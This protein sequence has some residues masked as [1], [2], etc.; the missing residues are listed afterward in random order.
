MFINLS[1]EQVEKETI[2]TVENLLGKKLYPA[3]AERLF[4]ES[5]VVELL[6]II[7]LFNYYAKQ[8][9]LRYA[10]GEY[11]DAIAELYGVQRLPAKPA[12]TTLRFYIEEPLP[13]DV[14]I[15]A[16]TRA[17]SDG[18]LMFKTTEEGKIPAGST[19]VDI[20]AECETPGEVGNGYLPG[21]INQLVDPVPYVVKVENITTS[22]G[23]SDVESDDRFRERIRLSLERFST[24]GPRLA[25]EYWVKTAHQDI[26]DV[27]VYSPSEG[28]VKVH[29]LVKNGE[30]PSEDM[31]QLVQDFLN[32]DK[33]RPLTDL[34]I[35]K[36][37]EVVSYSV[38]LT[39]WIHRKD[40]PLVSS[41][42]EKV[43]KA[44]NDFVAWTGSKIG[45]DILPEELI[46]RVKEAGAYRVKVEA[47]TYTEISQSQVAKASSVEINYGG[48]VDD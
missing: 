41:I 7:A 46:R 37:P 48:L 12:I 6:R 38:K 40:T 33:I 32:G 5:F 25:Y 43:Q 39:Y 26:S 35:V 17:T 15:P 24:A 23:G 14:V 3:S 13:F 44:V 27:S 30:L 42:Q 4:T 1:A 31:I 16:G 21:Q 36:P 47:P 20:P 34:V 8:N 19:Y 45:R 10:E 29:F 9:L 2:Q 22:L 18:N 11:L 28:V